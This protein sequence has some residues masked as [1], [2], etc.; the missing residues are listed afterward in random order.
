MAFEFMIVN[1]VFVKSLI[2]I[3]HLQVF[4]YFWRYYS[5][6]IMLKMKNKILFIFSVEMMV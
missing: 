4:I 1:L 2:C 3:S 6:K 5:L